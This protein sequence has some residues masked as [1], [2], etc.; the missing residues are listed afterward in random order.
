MVPPGF[1]GGRTPRPDTDE[2]GSADAVHTD[3]VVIGM[4]PGGEHV[5]ER[6]ADAGL[7]VTGVE[8]EL[9]GGECPYWACVPSKM[10]IRAANLLAEAHRVP[11]MAGRSTVVTDFAPVADRIRSEATD[12]WN[13]QVA[14]DRF[15]GKGGRFVR[16]RGTLSGPRQVSVAGHE[17]AARRGVVLATGTRPAIP[18]VPGLAAAPYWTDRDAI[19]IKEPPA[20]P[21][22]LGGGAVGVELAQAL[23]RFGTRVTVIEALDRLVPAEE[24]E[25]GDLLAQVLR[26]Q[27]IQI[28]TGVAATRIDHDP[29]TEFTAQLADGTRLT[30]ERLL[31]TT[32]RRVDLTGLG[33]EHAGLG[34]QARAVAVDGQM[35]AGEGLWAVGDITGKG[36]FTHV[37]MYQAE[38]AVRD[39]L[40]SPGPDA[41]YRAL[42]KVTFTDPEIGSVGLTAAEARE[43]GLS[44]WRR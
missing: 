27:D 17:F 19:A 1:Q 16:G 33:V 5:A 42:P 40:G 36:A 26:A 8:A 15:T 6:L 32:G 14:V 20:S 24:P 30:G 28:H 11:G 21:I 10:M 22:V 34:P 23:A 7:D 38:I 37:A 9:V 12:D 39:I 35:R 13:D 41:D 43:Q 25:A 29:A 4:G 2:E 18:P 31:V 3:V 44:G